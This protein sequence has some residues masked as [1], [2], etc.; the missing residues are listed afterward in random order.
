MLV[1]RHPEFEIH[2]VGAS[3][4]KAISIQGEKLSH[5]YCDNEHI[6]IFREDCCSHKEAYIGDIWWH[7]PLCNTKRRRSLFTDD[8]LSK[9]AGR[10]IDWQ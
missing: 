3:C 9:M 5:G 6:E 10:N 7:C 8:Y 2:Q 1:C 4:L